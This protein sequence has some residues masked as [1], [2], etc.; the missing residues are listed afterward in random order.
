MAESG[1][2][3]L[4]L[5][6]AEQ[7]EQRAQQA[8]ADLAAA[9][10]RLDATKEEPDEPKRGSVIEFRVKFVSGAVTYT[11]VAYR[12]PSGAWYRTGSTD[13]LNWAT[14]LDFMYRD[15][16]AKERGVGFYLYSRKRAEWIGRV[17]S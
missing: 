17:L 8:A 2:R 11:Y 7:A 12:A 3:A 9:L 16:T 13:A 10:A 5:R 1:R 6:Q 14:L 15:E 4:A